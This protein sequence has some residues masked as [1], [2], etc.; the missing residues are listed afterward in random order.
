MRFDYCLPWNGRGGYQPSQRVIDLRGVTDD[1][2]IYKAICHAGKF[3]EHDLLYH[4]AM[5]GPRGGM[6][7]DV[8]ANIGNHTVYF[9]AFLADAVVSVEPNPVTAHTLRRNVEAN[10]LT[11]VTIAQTGLASR[12]GLGR[13]VDPD[14]QTNFGAA[15]VQI[16]DAT[17]P[18]RPNDVPLTTLDELVLPHAQRLGTPVRFIKIDVEGMELEVLGG[19]SRTL[20]THRPQLAVEMGDEE[21]KQAVMERLKP[22]GYQSVGRF[23]ASPTYHL[24][25]PS[26]HRLRDMPSRW[27]CSWHMGKLKTLRSMI[28]WK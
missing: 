18:D 5:R 1:D 23:C 28:G 11:N 3:Y 14:G 24:I 27:A 17:D 10:G 12:P 6:F 16:D 2:H 4:I 8:G 22:H 13:I 7:V 25:D 20:Q 15:R 19:A 21:K 26:G 9:A